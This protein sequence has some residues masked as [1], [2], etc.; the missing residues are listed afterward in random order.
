MT[1]YYNYLPTLC[2]SSTKGV[3]SIPVNQAIPESVVIAQEGGCDRTPEQRH[4]RALMFSHLV[5]CNQKITDN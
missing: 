1:R 2:T 4:M 5:L 3:L